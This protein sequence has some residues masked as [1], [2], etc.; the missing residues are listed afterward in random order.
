MFVVNHDVRKL[1]DLYDRSGATQGRVRSAGPSVHGAREFNSMADRDRRMDAWGACRK[2]HARRD[3]TLY[4]G[5]RRTTSPS[6]TCPPACVPAHR[7]N[8]GGGK[9]RGQGAT[10]GAGTSERRAR[11]GTVRTT[12]LLTRPRRVL[13]SEPCALRRFAAGGPTIETRRD[14]TMIPRRK[15][16]AKT[17]PLSSSSVG[18]KGTERSARFSLPASSAATF[19]VPRNRT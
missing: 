17:P 6:V 12:R 3:T 5:D 2:R 19:A 7:P 1:G 9:V 15:P 14:E 13:L 11:T 4:D 10:A 18:A 16:A 8:N